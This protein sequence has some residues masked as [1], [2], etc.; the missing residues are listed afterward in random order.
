VTNIKITTT[1][2]TFFQY[3][4]LEQVLWGGGVRDVFFL[5][6]SLGCGSYLT[7]TLG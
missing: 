1:T 2:T 5:S 7:P 4:V 3:L 6:S